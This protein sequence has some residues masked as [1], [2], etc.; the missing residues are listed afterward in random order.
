MI[1][2]LRS[3]QIA[4]TDFISPH[5]ISSELNWSAS[6]WTASSQVKS[7]LY[8]PRR[9]KWTRL[10]TL[11]HTTIRVW[12]GSTPSCYHHR[13]WILG[14]GREYSQFL[15]Y[16]K[17]NYRTDHFDTSNVQESSQRPRPSPDPAGGAYSDPSSWWEKAGG[18]GAIYPLPKNPVLTAFQATLLLP[19]RPAV[20]FSQFKPCT[21]HGWLS[22][23]TPKT[24]TFRSFIPTA[25]LE[26]GVCEDVVD[27]RVFRHDRSEVNNTHVASASRR[28]SVNARS[29]TRLRTA[30][31]WSKQYIHPNTSLQ[32]TFHQQNLA[33]SARPA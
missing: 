26:V 7:S 14:V 18:E 21:Q 15:L 6:E 20:H 12:T 5:L 33:C 31:L 24:S 32:S 27:G 29:I 8:E 9:A 19:P 11:E 25:A 1:A 3:V 13:Y 30:I 23:R 16:P 10:K 28:H 2:V 22:R 17:L 4:L